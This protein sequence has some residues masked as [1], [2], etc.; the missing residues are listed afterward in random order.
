M[1][2]RQVKTILQSR[3]TTDGAG[4]RLQRVF[5]NRETKLTD[6]FLL[7]DFFGSDNPNDYIAGFPWH[8]HRGIET[9]TYLLEGKVK[10]EDSMGNG[11]TIEAGDCQW[12]TAGSGII[13]QEMPKGVNG[14][15]RGFQ[16]WANLPSSFKM[17]HPRYREIKAVDIPEVKTKSGARVKIICGELEG[18]VGPVREIVTQ[19]EYLDVT[20]PPN[21]V[22]RH[23][24]KPGHT[25]F[26]YIFEGKGHFSEDTERIIQTGHLVIFGDGNEIVA[27]SEE[28]QLRFLLISG[29]PIGEPIAWQ[30]PIVMNT[31]EELDQA[32]REYRD[33]T[34]IKHQ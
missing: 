10:H 23:P 8:P 2:I 34:F 19:P 33:G 1:R 32:F 27:S 24:T 28:G 25:V 16:L 15:M 17:M 22:F 13:H 11:G 29:K 18:T 21:T 6:P 26:V 30:G 31:Q 14:A 3:T 5:S 20:L 4:V 12:M 7:L 9:I